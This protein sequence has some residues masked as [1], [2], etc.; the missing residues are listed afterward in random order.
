MGAGFVGCIIM[1]GLLARGADLTVLIRSGR[2]VS[3]MMPPAASAMIQR[4]CEAR[5][6]NVKGGT[7]TSRIDQ[8][9]DEL[10]ITLSNGE[11]LPADLYLSVV[12]VTP[13]LEFLRGSGIAIDAGI[14]VDDCMRTSV[15][16]VFAAGDVV[17][18]RDCVSG[19]SQINAIQPNAVEQGRIAANN[20]VDQ[21]TESEGSL[22]CNVLDTLGLISSSF[23][24]W[25]GVEGGENSLQM[26]EANFRYLNLQ[27]HDD[28]LIGASSVGYTE[29]IGA[30]RGLIQ[31]RHPL[32]HWK[33]ALLENPAR[34]V[35]AYLAL[36]EHKGLFS[37][38]IP[39]HG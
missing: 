23:G 31:K 22:A 34:F 28:I 13:T 18:A 29:H 39:L 9:G 37:H 30:L 4:W 26:D 12:G 16:D 27:F 8:T 33:A 20:M 10:R 32:G 17:E 35:E 36:V 21:S 24:Q 38:A 19:R 14:V 6:V 15:P 2:V 11:V 25:Q 7:Q 5:G 3:R 1:H